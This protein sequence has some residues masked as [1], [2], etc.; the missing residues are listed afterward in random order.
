MLCSGFAALIYFVLI[1]LRFGDVPYY[2][3]WLLLSFANFFLLS[4]RRLFRRKRQQ[5]EKIVLQLFVFPF[6]TYVLFMLILCAIILRIFFFSGNKAKEGLEYLIVMGTDLNENKMS[7]QLQKR[8]D[9][10]ISYSKRNP[11]TM[12]V[13]S[14]GRGKQDKS[15]QATV[16]YYYM[17]QRGIPPGNII[18]EFYSRSTRYKIQYSIEVIMEDIMGEK[19]AVPLF[20]RKQDSKTGGRGKGDRAVPLPSSVGILTSAPNM[21]RAVRMAE[22]MG[23][24]EVGTIASEEDL[25]LSLHAYT[26]EALVF[27]FERLSGVI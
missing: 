24:K 1:V 25:L 26:K 11:D 22:K 18:M 5:K 10:A 8:L 12:L 15:T 3:F 6:A 14:G 9:L 7:D 20:K 16:M 4:L 27:F 21:Y 13:L 19:F 17:I 23:L 2:W